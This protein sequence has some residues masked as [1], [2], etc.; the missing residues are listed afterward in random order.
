MAPTWRVLYAPRS[1]PLLPASQ[2]TWEDITGRVKVIGNGGLPILITHGRGE[3]VD[4][5][6]PNTLRLVLDNS[7]GFFTTFDPDYD[8]TE[9]GIM[10]RVIGST[11]NGIYYR[12]TGP[13]D[14]WEIADWAQ[15][16]YEKLITVTAA[17]RLKALQ[18]RARQLRSML[19]HETLLTAPAALYPLTEGTGAIQAVNIAKV[20]E[21]ALVP[22]QTNSGAFEF[23]TGSGITAD[24]QPAP[25]WTESEDRAG[26]VT[27]TGAPVQQAYP[28]GG[29]DVLSL[30]AW[31][32]PEN[33]PVTGSSGVVLNV[34][35]NTFQFKFNLTTAKRWRCHISDL[36]QTVFATVDGSSAVIGQLYHL[37]AVAQA[38][39][40]LQF[41]VNGALFTGD[42]CPSITRTA[43]KIEVG[44]QMSGSVSNVGIW[45]RALTQSEVAAMYRA[46]STGTAGMVTDEVMRLVLSYCGIGA[47]QIDL[48][49]V[50]AGAVWIL[51]Q[52][53]LGTT[54]V[55]GADSFGSEKVGNIPMAGRRPG[56]VLHEAEAVEGGVL[57][58]D[59]AGLFRIH[60]RATRYNAGEPV[61]TFLPED[62]TGQLAMKKNDSQPLINDATVT[63]RG[64]A[65]FRI[66]DEPSRLRRGDWPVSE[67]YAFHS[68]ASA[69]SR[70]G[71]FVGAYKA[72][73]YRA[74]A[75]P[76]DISTST[77]PDD[78]LER[79]I[80]D[81]VA[82]GGLSSDAPSLGEQ[83]LEGWAD[84]IGPSWTI[85]FNVSP[86]LFG[87]FWV[88]DDPVRSVL[89]TS[90]VLAY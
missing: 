31:V 76:V 20:A 73:R 89:G 66:T 47:D 14:G 79:E 64:G 71:Y 21:A 18:Q 13:I 83:W 8:R 3:E 49:P 87:D 11:A 28:Y 84:E 43:S 32:T 34:G 65:T 44:A 85:T 39:Q 41:Y 45:R 59:G 46:G 88:L 29:A 7:D 37:V 62:I 61:V 10:I 68:D 77:R 51:G 72:P 80:S 40:P 12:F 81:L 5:I 2:Q 1:S 19:E 15:Y 74:S 6:S 63:R 24:T 25:R 53:M 48:R 69:E 78:F 33:L 30:A 4:A 67:E 75:V 22:L 70:A 58:V 56:E 17:D 36:P 54:T 86:V 52:S 60:P 16:P 50:Q 38:G 35:D 9:L 27:L 90:T 42:T 82:F 26:W 23:G 55:L 57:F